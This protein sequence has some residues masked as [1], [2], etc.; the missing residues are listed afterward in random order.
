MPALDLEDA[1][2]H[3]PT[4]RREPLRTKLFGE[5]QGTAVTCAVMLK[6]L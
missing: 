1:A 6:P 4:Y 5:F 3:R 2:Q